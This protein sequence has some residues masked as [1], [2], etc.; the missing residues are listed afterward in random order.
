M[1]ALLPAQRSAPLPARYT[2]LVRQ[3]SGRPLRNALL[4]SPAAPCERSA[5]TSQP[6]ALLPQRPR[7]TLQFPCNSGTSP[8]LLF[9]LCPCPALDLHDY[10]T[11]RRGA[12]APICC[13]H[14]GE[15]MCLAERHQPAPT[16][17]CE[18]CMP[19]HGCE[20]RNWTLG[21]LACCVL[22]HS[23]VL[24]A[25]GS[26]VMCREYSG[27]RAAAS[28]AWM[29]SAARRRRGSAA[30]PACKRRSS[31]PSLLQ[32]LGDRPWRRQR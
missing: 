19:R 25:A 3:A 5:N 14:C 4:V 18:A 9:I 30:K 1:P 22:R 8:L 21:A 10:L 27:R 24:H 2:V 16:A 28:A 31:T 6:N 7:S 13:W 17:A 12:T 29:H 23:Q 26:S 32:T 15:C 11:L 20:Q